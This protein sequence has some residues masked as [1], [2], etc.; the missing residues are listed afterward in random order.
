MLNF[1]PLFYSF[2]MHEH[3]YCEYDKPDMLWF[4]GQAGLLGRE[5]HLG[6]KKGL[7][8]ELHLIN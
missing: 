1:L 3:F 8:L 6:M 5:I 2:H 7:A 4:G